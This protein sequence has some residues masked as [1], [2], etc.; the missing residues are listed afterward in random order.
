MFL[1]IDS[2]KGMSSSEKLSF[3]DALRLIGTAT[4]S[5]MEGLDTYVKDN[6]KENYEKVHAHIYDTFNILAGN[7]L[8]AFDNTRSPATDLTAEAILRAENEILNEAV[9]T[10]TPIEPDADVVELDVTPTETD[11]PA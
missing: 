1:N 7:I 3:D 4:I 2:E 6:D 9:P 11:S 5:I 10:P 8:D